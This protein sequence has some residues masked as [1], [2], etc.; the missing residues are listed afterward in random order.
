MTHLWYVYQI[1]DQLTHLD[2]KNGL[3]EIALNKESAN[4]DEVKTAV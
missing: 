1:K 2:R 4:F 3:F